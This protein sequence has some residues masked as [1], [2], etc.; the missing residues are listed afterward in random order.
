M[1]QLVLYD[2]T[3]RDGTQCEG[4]SLSCNDKLK[5]AQK[6]DAF[7]VHYIEGGWPGSNP[8]DAEFFARQEELHLKHAKI[9]AFGSTRYKNTTCEQDNNI[10][11]L[12]KSN[13]P[14]VAIFGKSWTLHAT[15]I[16]ETTLEENLNMIADSIRYFKDR[17]KEVFFDAEHFF[18]GY[19]ADAEYAIKTLQVAA[20]NGAKC[21]VLCD[22]NGGALPYE[23]ENIT[24][25]IVK[26]FP[27]LEIGI[28]AHNDGEVG[29]A[30]TLAAVRVGATHV[31]GTMNGY[32]ERVGNANLVSV[33]PNLQ[34][35]MDFRCVSDEQLTQLTQLSYYIH[36][37]ANVTPDIHQPFVGDSAFAHKGGIHVSAILKVEESYQHIDPRLIGND[38]RALVSEMAGKSNILYKASEFGIDMTSDKARQILA[39][40]KE[41]ESKGHMFEGA[42]ASVN[43]MLHRASDAYM[44]PFEVIDFMVIAEDRRGP[45]VFTEA[46][47]KVKVGDDVRH[48]VAEGNGPVDALNHAL[49]KALNYDFPQLSRIHLTDYKVRI[50]DSDSG[51][52][53]TTRVMIDFHEEGTPHSAWTTVSAHTN[54][55]E[56]S[57][58]ALIDGIEYGL[59]TYK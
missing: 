43:I 6:L 30:N 31:Q 36:E 3:L 17:G 49:R 1:K 33:I 24:C 52:G 29:V 40:I 4:I 14:V 20:D 59:L 47:V 56:A 11:M 34:L 12:D 26:R 27:D 39:Q 5:I 35:K 58:R 48:T 23:I 37:I 38:K 25:T 55:I 46:T 10:Q 42:E 45:G 19:K 22:T 50:L 41:M 8:K 51:T 18:D 21:L 32:G 9:A 7:G 28:H 57:W 15:H 13:T 53:S 54:I 2:T 44:P 16:L